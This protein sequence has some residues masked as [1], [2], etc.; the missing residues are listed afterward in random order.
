MVIK[1]LAVE[2]LQKVNRYSESFKPSEG[3]IGCRLAH[4]LPAAIVPPITLAALTHGAVSGEGTA[5]LLSTVLRVY[6]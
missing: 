1:I 3:C 6:W 5:L 2:T 4:N